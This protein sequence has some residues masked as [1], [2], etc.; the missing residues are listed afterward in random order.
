V[1]PNGRVVYILGVRSFRCGS[2]CRANRCHSSF[3]RRVHGCRVNA[4]AR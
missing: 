2:G 4:I 3:E 1:C